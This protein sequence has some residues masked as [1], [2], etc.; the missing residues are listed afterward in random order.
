MAKNSIINDLLFYPDNAVYILLNENKKLALIS[1]VK[2]AQSWIARQAVDL[3]NDM[4]RC[5][6]IND[7]LTLQT[8]VGVSLNPS[9]LRMLHSGICEQYIESGYVVFGAGTASDFR[10]VYKVTKAGA[11]LCVVTKRNKVIWSK[12][13][14]KM[15]DAKKYAEDKTIE[16]LMK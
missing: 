9:S 15:K 13:F 10:T 1:I 2:N 4:H 11:L 7:E 8:K 14:D 3:K 5:G 6:S 12:C 16:E